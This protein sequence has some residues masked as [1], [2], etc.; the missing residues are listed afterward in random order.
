MVSKVHVPDGWKL[1]RLGDV[2]EVAGGSTP[3]RGNGKFWGGSIPWVVPSE[4]TELPSRYLTTTK[5]SIT[6]AG[7]KSA[8]L[9]F[10]P[11]GSVLLTSRATIGI[12]AINTLPVVTNQ[13]FQ[14]LVCK[15]GTDALW[16]YY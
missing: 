16:L 11:V 8:G 6:E 4:L 13:G 7:M 15:N 14:N 2:A 5:E 1:V 9:R 10:I 3:S 12:T